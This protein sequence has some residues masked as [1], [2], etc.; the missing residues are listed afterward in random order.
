MPPQLPQ[1]YRKLWLQPDC[2]VVYDAKNS[3]YMCLYTHLLNMY[4]STC[5]FF[6]DRNYVFTAGIEIPLKM[7]DNLPIQ[8]AI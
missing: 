6:W 5:S 2:N 3:V 4:N 1:Q 7:A 8:S